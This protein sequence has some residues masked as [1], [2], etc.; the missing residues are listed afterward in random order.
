MNSLCLYFRGLIRIECD[1]NESEAYKLLEKLGYVENAQRWLGY[2]KNAQR[3]PKLINLE[4]PMEW[5]KFLFQLSFDKTEKE[6][7]KVQVTLL[8]IIILH[9][10][11]VMLENI[12]KSLNE[13]DLESCYFGKPVKVGD[14]AHNFL[15]EDD[16]WLFSAN[17]LHLATKYFPKGLD[18]LLSNEVIKNV[19]KC[20]IDTKTSSPRQG[21]ISIHGTEENPGWFCFCCHKDQNV[22]TELVGRN[23][24]APLHIAARKADSVATR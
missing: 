15:I 17:C 2:V 3:W 10:D 14:N 16:W 22:K 11:V 19:T 1:S 4:L 8:H 6:K 5:K 9:K 20:L 24:M 12:L 18:L 13:K 7:I 23:S 21:A